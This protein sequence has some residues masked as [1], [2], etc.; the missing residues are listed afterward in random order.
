MEKISKISIEY[1]IKNNI[2]IDDFISDVFGTHNTHDT[3]YEL[4][5]NLISILDDF[6][7][8]SFGGGGFLSLEKKKEIKMSKIKFTSNLFNKLFCKKYNIKQPIPI[9]RIVK[10][11]TPIF[12]CSHILDYVIDK[13]V[14]KPDISE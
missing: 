5:C 8:F 14:D 9:V 1:A 11:S 3:S 4:L 2:S 6:I 13:F 10:D 12:N 7:N